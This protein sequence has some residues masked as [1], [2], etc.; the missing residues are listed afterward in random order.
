MVGS[1]LAKSLRDLRR[2]FAWWVV[3]LAAYVAMIVSV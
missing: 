2:S 3:G 1:V